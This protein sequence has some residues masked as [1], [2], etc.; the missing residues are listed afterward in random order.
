MVQMVFSSVLTFQY[1]ANSFADVTCPSHA[2]PSPENST[3]THTNSHT[4]MIRLSDR[5]RYDPSLWERKIPLALPQS[6]PIRDLVVHRRERASKSLERMRLRQTP[7]EQLR[8]PPL[9]N[10]PPLDTCQLPQKHLHPSVTNEPILSKYHENPLSSAEIAGENSCWSRDQL[11]PTPILDTGCC[12]W[13]IWIDL[14]RYGTEFISRIQN[15]AYIR[16][17]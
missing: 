14:C 4:N 8:P 3:H 9:L 12:S 7:A 11:D 6:G 16:H 13:D 17:M 10:L 2:G 5:L 15:L 1:K